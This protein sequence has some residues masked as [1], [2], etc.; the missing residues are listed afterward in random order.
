MWQK[1]PACLCS[2]PPS[3]VPRGRPGSRMVCSDLWELTNGKLKYMIWFVR[4]PVKKSVENSTLGGGVRTKSLFLTGSLRLRFTCNMQFKLSSPDWS[5]G[6][7]CPSAG[8]RCPPV[9]P[10]APSSRWGRSSP[11]TSNQ[12]ASRHRSQTE[13]RKHQT[14]YIQ[15]QLVLSTM[16]LM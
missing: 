1:L 11:C 13:D 8:T 5:L 6:M 4:E 12:P 2:R 9:W 16:K 7:G 14:C 10:A 3:I 15:T